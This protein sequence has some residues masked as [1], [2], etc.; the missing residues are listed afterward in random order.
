MQALQLAQ[1]RRTGGLASQSD[2]EQARTQLEQTRS[3]LVD[4][5]VGRA[6]Y[7]HA[8]ALLVG[9]SATNY[10]VA[11]RPLAGDPPGIPTGIPSELLRSA[12]QTSPPPNAAWLP[13]T[14]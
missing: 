14:H 7:E 2:V 10:H 8:I 13:R 1:D 6:Q 4:L 5:G 3:E 11:E 9:V 12:G